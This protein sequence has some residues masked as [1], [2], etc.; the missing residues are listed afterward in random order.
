[1][2]PLKSCNWLLQLVPGR[3]ALKVL[4]QRMRRI[5]K[6]G[7]TK[8]VNHLH[9]RVSILEDIQA[10]LLLTSRETPAPVTTVDSWTMHWKSMLLKDNHQDWLHL[11]HSA[12]DL[13]LSPLVVGQP[14]WQKNVWKRVLLFFTER[15][16]DML[17]LT[18]TRIR[19]EE[20]SAALPWVSCLVAQKRLWLRA[21]NE[22]AK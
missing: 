8:L 21:L 22:K 18:K 15:S 10:N 1:M 7:M 3:R 2:V 6:R 14:D 4:N 12:P 20:V 17:T 16:T 11:P 9:V 13:G 5:A 19:N